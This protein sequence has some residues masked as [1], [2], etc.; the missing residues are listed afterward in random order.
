MLYVCMCYVIVHVIIEYCE[1]SI[2]Y[3]L[4]DIYLTL[5]TFICRSLVK[6]L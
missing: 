1:M 2:D 5:Y 6:I 4:T 3:E